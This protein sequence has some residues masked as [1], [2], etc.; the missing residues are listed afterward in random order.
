MNTIPQKQGFTIVELMIVIVVIAILAAITIVGYTGVQGRAHDTAVQSDLRQIAN[1]LEMWRLDSGHYPRLAHF[2][3][4]L[5][6]AADLL[7]ITDGS[8][9]ATHH[10]AAYCLDSSLQHFALVAVSTS[11][12]KFVYENGGYRE[13]PDDEEW[14]TTR[15]ILCESIGVNDPGGGPSSASSHGAW[16]VLSGSEKNL[17]LVAN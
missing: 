17:Q 10:S 12:N 1:Q 7:Q 16:L 2:T 6:P 14:S 3:G 11:G 8:Y 9:E 4:R 5:E 15:G 13:Y